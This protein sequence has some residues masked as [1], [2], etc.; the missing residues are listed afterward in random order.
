MFKIYTKTGDDGTT[1]L[2]Q[3]GRVTKDSSVIEA[4]GAVDELNSFTGVLGAYLIGNEEWMLPV[5]EQIAKI[6]NH[7]FDIGAAIA[8]PL[9]SDL[10]SNLEESLLTTPVENQIDEMETELAPIKQFILPGGTLAASASHVCRSVC[11]NAE[12]RVISYV[13][14]LV[15]KASDPESMDADSEATSNA[16]AVSSV[17]QKFDAILRYMNRLSDYFFVLARFLNLKEN[18]TDVFWQPIKG[19]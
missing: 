11:R 10:L 19:K 3:R 12:R 13:T 17:T 2:Y 6:Q 5:A 4:I 18:R 7:L 15:A 14:S 8:A 9:D 1:G 16:E